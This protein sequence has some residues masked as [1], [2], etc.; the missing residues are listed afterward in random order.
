MTTFQVHFLMLGLGI[1]AFLLL[2]GVYTKRTIH[3][4]RKPW[5]SIFAGMAIAASPLSRFWREPGQGIDLLTQSL[6]VSA[7]C[8]LALLLL[9]MLRGPFRALRRANKRRRLAKRDNRSLNNGLTPIVIDAESRTAVP[10][11]SSTTAAMSISDGNSV[12]TNSTVPDAD[13]KIPVASKS[14][15]PMFDAKTY[16]DPLRSSYSSTEPNGSTQVTQDKS[17]STEFTDATLTDSKHNGTQTSADQANTATQSVPEIESVLPSKSNGIGTAQLDKEISDSNAANDKSS[18]ERHTTVDTSVSDNAGSHKTADKQDVNE[19]D[20]VQNTVNDRTPIELAGDDELVTPVSHS[21]LAD[22]ALST[23]TLPNDN[24]GLDLSET[25]QLFAEIRSQR[26]ELTLPDDKELKD[27]TQRVAMDD[28]DFDSTLVTADSNNADGAHSQIEYDKELIEEAEVLDVDDTNLDFGNDLTGEYAHPN[29]R[30]ANAI[31][32]VDNTTAES[33]DVPETLIDALIAAKVSAASVQAQISSLEESI[34]EIDAMRESQ[35]SDAIK[36]NK[37]LESALEQK[38]ALLVSEDETRKAAESVIAAQHLIIDRARRKQV[39]AVTLLKKE[40]QRLQDLQHEVERSKK[41]A[42]T[43]AQLA[44]KAAVAQQ[45]IRNV[46]KREQNARLKSQES[47]RKAV[48]IA[49]NAISAL[50]A[51]ERKRGFTRH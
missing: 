8:L 47:T 19:T 18:E 45:E 5:L 27:A 1:L 17:K 16:N 10:S 44:R 22:E 21:L 30:S 40:R 14:N 35:A 23:P 4:K 32:F 43:A 7:I 42:R 34:E 50:A 51:E 36:N 46:A 26:D 39:L 2:A 11:A 37:N 49:R 13:A 31:N 48:T 20:D 12:D 25:E 33:V 38:N 9:A 3:R 15:V 24:D 28:L 41:M 6:L 29:E